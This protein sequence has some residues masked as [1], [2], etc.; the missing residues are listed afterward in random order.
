MIGC[1]LGLG[2]FGQNSRDGTVVVDHVRSGSFNS[3]G[4][5]ENL[6]DNYEVGTGIGEK[7][8]FVFDLSGITGTITSATFRVNAGTMLGDG[9][10][11]VFD[12]ETPVA[13][14]VQFYGQNNENPSIYDELA[15]GTPYGAIELSWFMPRDSV[16]D[17][18]LSAA[19]VASLN[20]AGGLWALSGSFSGH[21]A[22]NYTANS[23][24]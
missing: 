2:A 17:I 22:M 8:W 6:F 13:D 3:S 21:Y 19:A 5:S 14:L 12:V 24:F 23:G 4:R 7:N 15:T 18:D 1:L 16:V 10:Y 11:E 20:Q 9:L